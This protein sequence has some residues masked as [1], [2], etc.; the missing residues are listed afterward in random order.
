MN[1]FKLS[2]QK[3]L[4][5]LPAEISRLYPDRISHKF[6]FNGSWVEKKYRD[7]YLDI[8]HLACGF[9]KE[10]IKENDHVAFFCN[11]RYEWIVTDFAL[12]IN[13]TVSVPRASDTPFIE[14]LFILNHSDS[15]YLIIEDFKSLKGLI[16]YIEKVKDSADIDDELNIQLQTFSSLKKI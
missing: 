6:R 14:T 12:M 3:V 16:D 10:G 9:F 2:S 11:N 8:Q 15:S 5:D 13:K 7:F 1:N 4:T